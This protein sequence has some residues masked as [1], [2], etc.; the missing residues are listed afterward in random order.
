MAEL[1]EGVMVLVDPRYTSQTV[2]EVRFACAYP[3][4]RVHRCRVCGL[5]LDSYVNAAR[6]IL[7]KGIGVG[8]ADFKLVGDSISIEA[9]VMQAGSLNQEAH[10]FRDG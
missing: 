8:R 9:T 2:L 1:S 5:V 4:E 10:L 6:N 7:R 3:S